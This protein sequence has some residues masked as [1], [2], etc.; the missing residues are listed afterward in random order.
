MKVF[1]VIDNMTSR[2]G[3]ITIFKNRLDAQEHILSLAEEY[4]Y[5]KFCFYIDN[6]MYTITVD[7][8]INEHPGV[9]DILFDGCREDLDE[10]YNG[11]YVD[12]PNIKKPVQDLPVRISEII[13]FCD[14]NRP[15]NHVLLTNNILDYAY[16]NQLLINNTINEMI[17]LFKNKKN[18]RYM[19]MSGD[20]NFL[21]MAIYN[22]IDFN[23][24]KYIDEAYA[25]LIVSG[26][27][28]LIFVIIY[29]NVQEKISKIIIKN[30][31]VTDIYDKVKC[32]E[33][34]NNIRKNRIRK[35][36]VKNRKIG[37][38]E[39]CPCGSGKKYKKCC[40]LR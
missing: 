34:A 25:N 38:N 21:I 39:M 1:V 26:K 36:L 10:Y 17:E 16:D 6:N 7:N 28:S 5:N 2:D 22:K 31:Y 14:L 33:L 30:L 23:I 20:I 13:E 35:E 24:D 9:T 15:E 19:F 32:E 11:I 37:R 29:Y 3:F 12:I 27:T 18:P 40:L 8:L 4:A